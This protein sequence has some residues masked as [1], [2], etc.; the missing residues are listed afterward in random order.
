MD[1]RWIRFWPY[2]KKLDTYWRRYAYR[3]RLGQIGYGPTPQLR[4]G[5]SAGQGNGGCGCAEATSAAGAPGIS[6][7]AP[8]SRAS[9][10]GR[11]CAEAAS[12]AGAPGISTSAPRSRASRW[13]RGCLLGPRRHGSRW[14]LGEMGFGG[15]KNGEIGEAGSHGGRER[16]LRGRETRDDWQRFMEGGTDKVFLICPFLFLVIIEHMTI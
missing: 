8:W 7:S 5:G 3:T 13:G 9:R 6:T 10:W 1:T 15:E 2:P 11:G 12:S 16:R 14:D 4:R